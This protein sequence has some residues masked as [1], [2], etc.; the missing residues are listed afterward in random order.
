MDVES[1]IDLKTKL[2]VTNNVRKGRRV[3]LG[4]CKGEKSDSGVTWAPKSLIDLLAVAG[5]KLIKIEHLT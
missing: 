4:C 2:T 5:C 3:L 1:G